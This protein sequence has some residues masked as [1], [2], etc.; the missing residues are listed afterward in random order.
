[1]IRQFRKKG[2]QVQQRLT[3][4]NLL[5][6]L[7]NTPSFDF[8]NNMDPDIWAINSFNPQDMVACIIITTANG[9]KEVSVVVPQII[10]NIDRAV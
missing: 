5:A 4:T 8:F 7:E 6:L 10:V 9:S 3:Q 2:C 1:M